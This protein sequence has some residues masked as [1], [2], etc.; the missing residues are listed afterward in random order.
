[1]NTPT[2]TSNPKGGAG[3][4]R[5]SIVNWVLSS[6]AF[7]LMGTTLLFGRKVLDAVKLAK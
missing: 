3:H 6:L 7:K 1:M 5:I 2:S 4:T